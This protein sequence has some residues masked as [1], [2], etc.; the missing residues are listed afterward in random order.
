[1]NP[2]P[3]SGIGRNSAWR[4]QNEKFTYKFDSGSDAFREIGPWYTKDG[5][6]FSAE[7]TIAKLRTF[8]RVGFQLDA[9]EYEQLLAWGSNL[10]FMPEAG[11]NDLM[12][13]RML[14]TELGMKPPSIPDKNQVYKVLPIDGPLPW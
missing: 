8:A 10:R 12:F 9:P 3:P 13:M 1:M 11:G 6:E 4:H 5:S 14:M 2:S 7:E